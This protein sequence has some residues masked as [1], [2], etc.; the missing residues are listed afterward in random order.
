MSDRRIVTAQ[1]SRQCERCGHER[2]IET[3]GDV[4]PGFFGWATLNTGA[5][6]GLFSSLGRGPYDLCPQCAASQLS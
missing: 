4:Q 1:H 6:F 3:R 2:T 5:L